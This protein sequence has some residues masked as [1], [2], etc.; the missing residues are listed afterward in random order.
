MKLDHARSFASSIELSRR[1]VALGGLIGAASCLLA[2]PAAMAEPREAPLFRS[3]NFEFTTIRPQ[4]QLP[5]VRLFG[6]EGGTIDLA[7]LRGRPILL[8]FWA[9]W[10]AA[11][12]TELPL[13]D[14]LHASADVHVV[15]VSEDQGGRAVVTPFVKAL[16][17][18]RLPIYLDPNGYVGHSDPDN[19]RN[20][21]FALYGMPITYLIANSGLVVGYM[22]GSADWDSAQANALIDYLRNA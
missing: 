17:I 11:C 13:L 18:R 21:P 9:S 19:A 1:S 10:C 7:S 3:G 16:G 2:G 14:R 4:F 15:A 8:N 12:K 20:A 22:P 5:S 6:L